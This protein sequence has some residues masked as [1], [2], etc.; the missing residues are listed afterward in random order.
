MNLKI[1]TKDNCP[2]C[3]PAK[4]IAENLEKKG[5]SISYYDLGSL[6]GLSE[7]VYHDIMS[8]PSMVIVDDNNKEVHSWR[9][10][11]PSIED[12]KEKLKS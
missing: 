2:N 6:D 8:T 11:V 4:A 7:A 12:I 5:F 9:G 1:F 10:D 3:P